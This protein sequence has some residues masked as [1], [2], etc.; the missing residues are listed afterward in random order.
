M[1]PRTSVRPTDP[2]LGAVDAALF[3]GPMLL[4][5]PDNAAV[6]IVD[7]HEAA[8]LAIARGHGTTWAAQVRPGV[9]ALDVD[10]DHAGLAALVLDDLLGWCRRRGLWHVTRPSGGGPGRH[11]LVVIPGH[12]ES[13]LLDAIEA[14]RS[15]L[16]VPRQALDVRAAIR[17][18]SAPHRSGR[19]TP[20]PSVSDGDLAALGA[21]LPASPKRVTVARPAALVAG[22]LRIVP[23]ERSLPFQLPQAPFRAGDGSR[24][25]AEF[26]QTVRLA[27]SG[28]TA[29]QAWALISG[30]VG[31][32]SARC[33]RSWWDRYV[34][35]RVR[36]PEA[37]SGLDLSALVLPVIAV[38]RPLYAALDTRSRHSLETVL[39]AILERL[40]RSAR[41]PVPLSERD[42]ALATGLSRPTIRAAGVRAVDLGILTRTR[43]PRQD[44]AWVWALGE[45]AGAASLTYPSILTPRPS[46]WLHGCPAGSA[47]TLLDLHL[48]T[49][50]ATAPSSRQAAFRT[51]QLDALHAHHVLG[52]AGPV[53]LSTRDGWHAQL[54]QV[55]AERDQFYAGLRDARATRQAPYHHRI[56]ARRQRQLAWWH[57]LSRT[58]QDARRAE[59]RDRLAQLDPHARHAHIARLRDQR[60]L[61]QR[62]SREHPPE[63]AQTALPIP[64]VV[65]NPVSSQVQLTPV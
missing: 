41:R 5:G 51:A 13:G 54:A 37:V 61:V 10:L 30:I 34:W 44:A 17:P 46:R 43:H 49:S 9:V 63:A 53:P 23:T 19:P 39:M 40:D 32:K 36:A 27:N 3:T 18:L 38:S 62:L 22:P 7:G 6:G 14:W 31:G 20:A 21:A 28:A 48:D 56:L 60:Q 57:G 26:V 35:S 45:R 29:D 1:L 4:I 59:C 8:T 12:H 55:T 15:Q 33:G 11:H 25:A 2:V 58:E 47:T 42:L 16:K 52:D 50:R 65:P 64:M 24:S